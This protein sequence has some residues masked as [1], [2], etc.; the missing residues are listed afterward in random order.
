MNLLTP[1]GIEDWQF[2]RKMVN[3][4]QDSMVL[5]SADVVYISKANMGVGSLDHSCYAQISRRPGKK[6]ATLTSLQF[7][8]NFAIGALEILTNQQK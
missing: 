8:L 6:I 7:Q 1:L 3:A 5:R 4:L 2:P